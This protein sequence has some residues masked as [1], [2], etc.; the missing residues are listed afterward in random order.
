MQRRSPYTETGLHD[1]KRKLYKFNKTINSGGDDDDDDRT[2]R[3]PKEVIPTRSI[4]GTERYHRLI[5][6]TEMSS[7]RRIVKC[8]T[9]R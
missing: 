2:E 6:K 7:K 9:N 4:A 1:Q 5:P 3:V 8:V